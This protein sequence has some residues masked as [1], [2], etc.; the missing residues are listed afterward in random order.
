MKKHA[1]RAAR[2]AAALTC[3]AGLLATGATA[4]SA[5]TVNAGGVPVP[6]GTVISAPLTGKV[7]ITTAV[8]NASCSTGSFGGTVMNNGAAKVALSPPKLEFS[9]CTDTIAPFDLTSF[10]LIGASTATLGSGTG[11]GTLQLTGAQV[12]VG[13]KSG[14][15]PGTCNHVWNTA[16]GAVLN[17]DN[18]VT[19]TNVPVS[20]AVGFCG[21]WLP[22]TISGKFAP[23]QATAGPVTLAP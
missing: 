22:M 8:G 13:I 21:T 4:A 12:K 11:G 9:A 18:S 19:F 6:D 2:T 3:T 7:Y 20:S 5:T 10:T 16:S 14:G 17:S 23:L 1:R 15:L